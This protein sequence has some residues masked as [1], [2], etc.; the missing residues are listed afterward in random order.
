MAKIVTKNGITFLRSDWS[1]EDVQSVIEDKDIKGIFTDED[2]ISIL[3]IVS[4]NHDANIG[5]NWEV[6]ECAIDRHLA[7]VAGV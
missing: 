7:D 2:Y 1:I 4:R 5:I 3:H 6:I